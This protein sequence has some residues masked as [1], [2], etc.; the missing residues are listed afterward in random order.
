[1]NDTAYERAQ[2]YGFFLSLSS[3]LFFSCFG[4]ERSFFL[5]SLDFPGARD[6]Q[7]CGISEIGAYT[8]MHIAFASTFFMALSFSANSCFYSLCDQRRSGRLK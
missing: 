3:S 6:T 7:A 5:V 2:T 1:M 8:L 4:S